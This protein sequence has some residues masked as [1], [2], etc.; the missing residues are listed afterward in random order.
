M[1][2]VAALLGFVFLF[3]YVSANSLPVKLPTKCED[4]LTADTC[5]SLKA[6]A[7]KLRLNVQLVNEAVINAVK[8]SIQNT[9]DVIIFVR[10]TLVKKAT[11]FQCTD[12]LTA[13]QCDK[14]ALIGKNL[15]LSAIEV[16]EAVRQAVARPV[17]VGATL[18][19]AVLFIL[20]DLKK[21]VKCEAFV[22]EDVCKKVADYAISLKLSAEDATKAVKEAILQGA[23]NAADYYN[24]AT[25]YLRAQISCENVLSIETCEKVRKLA[26]KFSVSLTEVNSALRSAVASGIT[27]VTDLYKHAVKF[28]IEKW[29]QVLGDE[30]SMY[31]RSIENEANNRL[32]RTIDMLVDVITKDM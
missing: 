1:R 26:D 30:P 11:N 4:V 5:T 8:K 31:K 19:V 10:D 24:K 13:E 22:S 21:N 20:D 9:Q 17:E 27:K 29:N 15:K 28:I 25:E 18:Y 7:A 23:N 2:T 3:Q 12:A 6:V 14:I 16:A 32:V